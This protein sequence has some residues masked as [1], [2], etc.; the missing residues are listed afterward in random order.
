MQNQEQDRRP[1]TG[2]PLS[3]RS[4]LA[5][6]GAVAATAATSTL[7]IPRA[8]AGP[9]D[10]PHP[11]LIVVFLRG[12]ADGLTWVA[13][14]NDAYYQ[15]HRI[16][17]QTRVEP[18]TATPRAWLDQS[19]G[20]ALPPGAVDPQGLCDLKL[21]HDQG[22]L[23]FVHGTGLTNNGRS[24]FEAMAFMERGVTPPSLPP[25]VPGWFARY[26]S[27]NTSTN[28]LRGISVSPVLP[29][30]L[31][32]SPKTKAVDDLRQ[33]TFPG[34]QL[35]AA[36]RRTAIQTSYQAFTDPLKTASSDAFAALDALSSVTYPPCPPEYP[37]DA[38]GQP[39]PFAQ[40]MCDTA[41]LLLSGAVSLEA[42]HVNVEGWDH[43]SSQRPLSG[44]DPDTFFQ[45]SWN[46][47]RTL[48]AFYNHMGGTQETG[49]YVLVVMTEFGR[50]IAE[51]DSQGTD[52]GTGGVAMVMG[53]GVAA[54]AFAQRVFYRNWTLA[55]GISGVLDPTFS[56]DL[57]VTHD[58]RHVLGE[59]MR[60]RMLFTPS[61]L[62]QV[63]PNFTIQEQ[64][65]VG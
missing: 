16:Q 31:V 53:D 27:A 39:T 57:A 13:P 15:N 24:H 62:A 55:Q 29:T 65:I 8:A 25:A 4:F 51:N 36:L 30:S 47:S 18:P 56:E 33:V 52:H 32:G 48:G 6:T 21:P 49:R 23:T 10:A 61:Q 43:H 41:E 54:G 58:V 28:S 37:R 9:P 34:E 3:R 38:A 11:T 35:T 7:W 45:M 2:Q 17:G 40:A 64:G 60:K 14:V 5:G 12:G 22:D 26:V 46:V 1:R 20:W 63:F 42:V 44:T 59:I 19:D 50:R